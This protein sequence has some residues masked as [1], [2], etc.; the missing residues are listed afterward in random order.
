MRRWSGGE[1]YAMYIAITI[2]SGL[3]LWMAYQVACG[4]RVVSDETEQA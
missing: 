4:D 1:R 2:L 3:L